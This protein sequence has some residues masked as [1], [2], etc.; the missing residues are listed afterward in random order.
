MKDIVMS[1]KK[2][3]RA[4]VFLLCCEMANHCP[5]AGHVSAI[6]TTSARDRPPEATGKG[7]VLEPT[8]SFTADRRVLAAQL[9]VGSEF[10]MRSTS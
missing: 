5:E 8:G 4:P 9:T 3:M 2:G 7:Q 1:A 10:A 6:Q